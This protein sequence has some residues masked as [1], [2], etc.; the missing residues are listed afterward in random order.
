MYAQIET[1][2]SIQNQKTV[3]QMEAINPVYLVQGGKVAATPIS[4]PRP[5]K[6]DKVNVSNDHQPIITLQS[7][8]LSQIEKKDNIISCELLSI[9]DNVM[10]FRLNYSMSPDR[11]EPIIAGM[12]LYDSNRKVINAGYLPAA[13]SSFPNGS[14]EVTMVLPLEKFSSSY[15]VAFLIEQDQPVFVNER[16]RLVYYWQGNRTSQIE[17]EEFC[18]DYTQEAINQYH[19]AIQNKLPN[20]AS[21]IW[22]DDSTG[23]YN[24]CMRVSKKDAVNGS[25]LRNNYIEKHSNIAISPIRTPQLFLIQEINLKRLDGQL[26][27]P[28][29]GSS[30]QLDPGLGP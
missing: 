24:W 28:S 18:R 22:T 2:P 9:N 19:F 17:K 21:P 12:F 29:P 15:L 6:L 20:I 14:V 30:Y 7:A 1:L 26:E 10:K 13:L 3:M 11:Q 8:N 23:H 5:I 27:M 16:F 25:K 4:I